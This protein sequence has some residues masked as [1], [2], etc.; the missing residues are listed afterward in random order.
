MGDEPTNRGHR[1]V[2]YAVLALVVY[3]L[4]Y[5]LTYLAEVPFALSTF[6]DGA[7]YEAAA[8]DIHENPPLGTQ[9]FYLQG[10]YAYLLAL[11]LAI[12]PWISLGL[13]VQIVLGLSALAVFARACKT[14][15]GP[16]AGM[17]STLCLLAYPA[18]AFYENKYLSAELGVV[19]NIYAF[20]AAVWMARSIGGDAGRLQWRRWAPAAWLG[21]CVGASI[22]ARSNLI[23]AVPFC[24]WACVRLSQRDRWVRLAAFA[25]GGALAVAPMA[26]RN[27]AVTG[28]PDLGP[29]HGGGTSFYI[30]NNPDS[31]GTWNTIGGLLTGSVES[32][33]RELALELGVDVPAADSHPDDGSVRAK[34]RRERAIA[35]AIGDEM[36]SRGLAFLRDNPGDAA[37]LMGR[38]IFRSAGNAE[39]AQDYDWAGERELLPWSPW[40]G[41]P[42]GV[43]LALLALGWRATVKAPKGGEGLEPDPRGAVAWVLAGQ[44]VAVVAALLLF[45]TSAQHRLPLAVVAAV[46]AGPGVLEVARMVRTRRIESVASLVISITLLAQA[47]V[48]RPGNR[49]DPHA[50]HYYNLGIVQKD[51]GDPAGALASFDRAIELAPDQAF[52]RLRRAQL[53]RFLSK[54]DRAETDLEHI[55]QSGSAPPAIERA[56]QLEL[57][58]LALDR[59]MIGAGTLVPRSEREAKRTGRE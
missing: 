45:F 48:P 18:L 41:V 27:L 46:W 52:F 59:E 12:R 42:F 40:I 53:L 13:I 25:L 19:C 17:L 6:S 15:W 37:L 4:V 29:A 21:A 31:K 22:L 14:L 39:M 7:M 30:G 36:Y 2:S 56:A 49:R 51:T 8:F 28:S 34:A 57:E 35:R 43:L 10:A 47:S 9:T 55:V 3:R 50:V 5:H 24:A 33:R 1:L 16:R 38:K 23:L 26:A 32:E 54:L 20:G 58:L 44:A 11:G